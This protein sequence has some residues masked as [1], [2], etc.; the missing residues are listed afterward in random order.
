LTYSDPGYVTRQYR[1]ASKLNARIALHERFSTNTRGLQHWIFDHFD[2]PKAANILDVGCGPGRLWEENLDRIPERWSM[3]LTD[4]SP[5]MIAE[6]EGSLGSDRRFAFRVGDVQHL[7]FR[8]ESFDVVVANHMLYHVPDRPKAL[9]E[10]SRVLRPDGILYATTNGTR[11]HREMGW[12]QRLLDPSRP[13]DAYFAAPLGFSLENGAEQLSPYFSDVTLWRYRDALA[14]T[15]VEPLVTYLLS[16]SA[17]DTAAKRTSADEFENRVSE[18]VDRL[19]HEL[20]SRG[21]INITKDTGLFI[22]RK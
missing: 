1:D 11:M 18:L 10:I 19:E 21:T 5:G 2:P 8:G 7:L 16:G 3:T 17:A 6:A 14:V 12:M 15:E 9:S 13:T 20:A 22:A 4:A